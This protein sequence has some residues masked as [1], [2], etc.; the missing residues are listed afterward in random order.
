MCNGDEEN[1]LRACTSVHLTTANLKRDAERIPSLLSGKGTKKMYQFKSRVRYSECNAKA[2]ITL[3]AL[4]NYLQD[5]CT[6]QSEDLRI[7]VD[8]LKEHHEA[9]L[10]SS[11]QIVIKRYPKMGEE[12]TVSTWPYAFKSFYGYRNFTIEDEKGEVVAYANSVWIFLDTD[13]G[14]PKRVSEEMLKAYVFEEQYPMETAERKIRLPEEMDAGEPFAVQ[15][16]HID[17]NHHVNNEKYILMAEEYLTEKERVRE[18]RVDYRKAAVLGDMIYPQAKKM[19]DKTVVALC[20]EA[21]KPYAVIE[22][23]TE[24]GKESQTC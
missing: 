15:K 23:Q 22:F 5:C 3:P 9:W 7:G 6:F 20:D 14:R 4:V 17:T 12:I 13:S 18:V 8:Y 11:W 16:F 24:Q 21:G 1:G 2:E 19:K 10:L